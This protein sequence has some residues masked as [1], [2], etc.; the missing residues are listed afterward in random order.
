MVRR[1]VAARRALDRRRAEAIVMKCEE[2]I[3]S[4]MGWEGVKKV[5]SGR[6]KKIL[7][8]LSTVFVM[9]ARTAPPMA[10]SAATADGHGS[11]IP[12]CPAFNN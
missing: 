10:C 12:H 2:M 3:R 1:G 11:E 4:R 9:A 8:E 5:A 6:C 7:V